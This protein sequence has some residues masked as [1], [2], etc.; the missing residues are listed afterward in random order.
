MKSDSEITAALETFR[1]GEAWAKKRGD[2]D[3]VNAYL[4]AQAILEWAL[5]SDSPLAN[6]VDTSMK[7]IKT[8]AL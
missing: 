5:D 4:E 3:R 2:A 7:F 8:N 6:T 1:S